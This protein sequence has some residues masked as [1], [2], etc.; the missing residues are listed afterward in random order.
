MQLSMEWTP[1]GASITP[2][3]ASR[4][5]SSKQFGGRYNLKEQSH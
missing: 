5:K 3:G 2:T 4:T 1:I